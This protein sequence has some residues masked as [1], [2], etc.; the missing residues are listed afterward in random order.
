[1]QKFRV[2]VVRIPRIYYPL[3]ITLH[4]DLQ[5]TPNAANH[6]AT[7]LRMRV[8]DSLLIFN[9]KNCEYKASI[10]SITKREVVV[11]INEQQVNDRESPLAIHLIQAVAR[12]EKMDW[13]IQKASELGAHSI[14]P[15]IT[16]RSGVKLTDKRWQ[17]RLQHWQAVAISAAEQCGRNRLLNIQPVIDF[18]VLL[19]QPLTGNK[20]ILAPMA[21]QSLSTDVPLIAKSVQLLI[22]PEGGFSEQELQLATEHSFKAIKLGPRILR[23]ETAAIAIIAICQAYFG[24][25]R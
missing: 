24:D 3:D 15:I 2:N 5:L 19:E 1:M 9:N 4:T 16:R 25:L 22:G 8:G 14:T 7:V 17:K 11:V 21:T 6:V 10:R 20:F 18:N 23:T 13:I 12:G